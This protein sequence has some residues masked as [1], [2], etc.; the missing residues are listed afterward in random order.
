LNVQQ[1]LEQ[2][3]GKRAFEVSSEPFQDGFNRRSIVGALFL[4]F[5]ML[6]GAIYIGLVLGEGMGTAAQWVTI[7]LFGEVA[8]RSFTRL[9]RQEIYVLFALGGAL[10][11]GGGP[12]FSLIWNQYLVQGAS[13]PETFG[14]LHELQKHLWIAPHRGSPGLVHRT[15]FHPD[16]LPAIIVV[17]LSQVLGRINHFCLGY[18]LFRLTSDVEQLPFPMAPVAAQGATALAESYDAEGSWRW[19]V[20]GIATT[21]GILFGAVYTFIPTATGAIMNYPIQ[22]L[23]IPFIDWTQRMENSFPA[24]T[25]GLNPNIGLAFAG[26][27]MPFWTVIGTVVSSL[28]VNL[29]ANPILYH[30]GVLTTW[31]PG[32]GLVVARVVNGYDWWMGFGIGKALTVALI[33]IIAAVGMLAQSRRERAKVATVSVV[34]PA[35]LPGKHRGDFPI[36]IAFALWLLATLGL[37]ALCHQLVPTF[38]SWMLMLYGFLWTPLNSYVSAR[39]IGLTGQ[40]INFPYLREGS[41]ILAARQFN[42]HGVG[43]WFAPIP[44]GDHGGYAQFLREAILTRTKIT[45]LIKAELLVFPLLLGCSIM[46]CSLLWRIAPIPSAAYPYAAKMWP[47]GA[48]NTSLWASSTVQGGKSFI[49]EAITLPKVSWG[50]GVGLTLFG[51]IRLFKLP[52]LLFYGL[53]GGVGY[54]SENCLLLL[55]GALLGRFY[56]VQRFGKEQWRMYTPILAAGFACGMG[57]VTMVCVGLSMI[58]K[59]VI[60]S[61]Y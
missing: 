37:V 5:I 52:T 47:I 39:M 33:G 29:V 25:F 22:I 38:P 35:L 6:P 1:E 19:R 24:S 17:V 28:V 60:Q 7:V 61:V 4:A 42:Y 2:E 49:E 16:W 11:V 58:V 56:F 23:P 26:F 21:I 13:E 12:F 54:P 31:K 8:R 27:V 51:I 18:L 48:F 34:D 10:V 44:L 50:L 46:F 30:C 43:I 57:L 41:F 15:F 3:W 9:S 53:V 40:G 32:M 45:S 55:A 14:I 36:P 20:F 59:S